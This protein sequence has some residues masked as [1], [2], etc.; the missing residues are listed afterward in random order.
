MGQASS[1]AAS[2]EDGRLL[3]ATASAIFDNAALLREFTN[4]TLPNVSKPRAEAAD[5]LTEVMTVCNW[6]IT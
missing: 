3:N 5:I 4:V 6:K 1:A 2:P